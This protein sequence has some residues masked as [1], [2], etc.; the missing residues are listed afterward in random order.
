MARLSA[1]NHILEREVMM[2]TIKIYRNNNW[3]LAITM[4]GIQQVLTSGCH[5]HFRDIGF[6]LKVCPDFTRQC[7]NVY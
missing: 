6:L 5:D 3:A 2:F 1:I 7:R 4:P